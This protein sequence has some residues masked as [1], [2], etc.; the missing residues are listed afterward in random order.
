MKTSDDEDSI[1][2]GI[3]DNEGPESWNHYTDKNDFQGIGNDHN[4]NASN[5][6]SRQIGIMSTS[7]GRSSSSSSSS[8]NNSSSDSSN[9]SR[10]RSSSTSTSSSI[11]EE[12][13][14]DRNDLETDV[15]SIVED[16]SADDS[17]RSKS[18]QKNN[19]NKI[20]EEYYSHEYEMK[21]HAIH[22]HSNEIDVGEEKNESK[23]KS[24][25]SHKTIAKNDDNDNDHNNDNDDNDSHNN[26]DD[27]NDN[28][29]YRSGDNSPDLTKQSLLLSPF[30][31]N[32]E[33]NN[34]NDENQGILRKQIVTPSSTDF[35]IFFSASDDHRD[36]NNSAASGLQFMS[37]LCG[38]EVVFFISN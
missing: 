27:D 11:E 26:Y 20:V 1:E 17:N 34:E 25:S 10:S 36:L 24:D 14:D 29:G 4:Y 38:D 22:A 7:S 15:L 32:D 16:G 9:G 28:N 21:N 30:T 2:I 35:G 37:L 31:L 8:S 19:M 6:S 13:N 33:N 18:N 5:S 12:K 3:D 23:I